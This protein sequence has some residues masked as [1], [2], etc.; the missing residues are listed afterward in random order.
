MEKHLQSEPSGSRNDATSARNDV[1]RALGQLERSERNALEDVRLALCTLIEALG[2]DGMS[3][4]AIVDTVRELVSSPTTPEG[5][6]G[7]HPAAREALVQ[8]SIQWC[9]EEYDRDL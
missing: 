7:L 8:L 6:Y 4:D 1:V 3:Y 9:A 2:A 5:E